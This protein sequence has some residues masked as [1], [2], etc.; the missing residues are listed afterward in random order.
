VACVPPVVRW[1]PVRPLSGPGDWLER[2]SWVAP[3][4]HRTPLV[5]DRREL[6][7]R[8]RRAC[9][10]ERFVEPALPALVEREWLADVRLDPD[11]L[12]RH[13]ESLR[14]PLFEYQREGVRRF[15]ETGRMLLG[16]DMGLGKTAQAVAIGHVLLSVGRIERIAV[17]VPS[18][19][20][21]QWAS[22]WSRFAAQR[23][24]VVDGPPAERQAMYRS[25]QGI[26]ILSYEQLRR[27]RA[28]VQRFEPELVILDEAQRIKNAPTQTARSVKRLA[29]RWR[30]AL[31]GTPLENR[32]EELASIVEWIDD[33]ALEPRWR[34]APC[35]EAPAHA[36]GAPAA[37]AAPH[38]RADDLQRT[39]AQEVHQ[40]LAHDPR[41][42]SAPGA[43]RCAVQPEARRALG[44]TRVDR[45]RAAAQGRRVQSMAPDAAARRVGHAQPAR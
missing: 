35:E 8:L 3:E 33:M 2:V 31:T 1:N 18:P 12:D 28:Y 11:E 37:D 43:R 6:I 38:G 24:R 39:R 17:I 34:L 41:R 40:D 45:H 16:D 9:A 5:S 32:L 7:A 30:L 20:K 23:P 42:A 21:W 14:E 13:L 19:L 29:P 27:D 22:E 25:R 26:L 44:A 15:F 4:A 36:R 10:R